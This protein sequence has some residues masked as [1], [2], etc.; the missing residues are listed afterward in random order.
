[1][2]DDVLAKKN[3]SSMKASITEISANTNVNLE[4]VLDEHDHFI[5]DFRN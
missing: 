3:I 1:M 5:L 4:K 2:L